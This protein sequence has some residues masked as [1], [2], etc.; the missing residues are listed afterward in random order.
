[1][2]SVTKNIFKNKHVL[3][4]YPGNNRGYLSSDS[5]N[6]SQYI[7]FKRA[8]LGAFG[9]LNLTLSGLQQAT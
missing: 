3:R 4:V 7:A 8:S 6:D 9:A 1:M 5:L 2:D